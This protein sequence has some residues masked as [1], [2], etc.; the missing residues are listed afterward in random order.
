MTYSIGVWGFDNDNDYCHDCDLIEAKS[1]QEA[2]H[3][4]LTGHG[5]GGLLQK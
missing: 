3:M 4:L 1:F 2:L 5:K